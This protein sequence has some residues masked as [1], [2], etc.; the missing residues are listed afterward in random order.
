MARSVHYHHI[1][2]LDQYIHS[3]LVY[4]KHN[5]HEEP[6]ER[7]IS[8]RKTFRTRSD[9]LWGPP[10]LLQN[11]HRFSLSGVKRLGRGVDHPPDLEPRLKKE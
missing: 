5:G 3:N 11:E 1:V 6:H 7:F 9:R 10:S 4:Y 2:V 8:S